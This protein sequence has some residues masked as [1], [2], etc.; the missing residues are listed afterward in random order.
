MS[1]P[2]IQFIDVY[3]S[4]IAPNG[5]KQRVLKGVNFGIMPPL[6]NG[7]KRNKRERAKSY[8]SRSAL[9]LEAFLNR[10]AF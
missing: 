4:F 9:E 6:E 3:K 5:E 2:I 7:K 8:A 1:E 10:E